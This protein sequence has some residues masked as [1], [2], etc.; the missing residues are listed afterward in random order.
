MSTV[1]RQDAPSLVI[2]G[3]LGSGLAGWE[4]SYGVRHM[5]ALPDSA[6][7]S[8]AVYAPRYAA[9]LPPKGWIKQTLARTDL[10][11]YPSQRPVNHVKAKPVGYATLRLFASSSTRLDGAPLRDLREAFE[12]IDAEGVLDAP[13]GGQITVQ[14]LHRNY[15]SGP[16]RVG[17]TLADGSLEISPIER[18]L[19]RL[20]QHTDF[21]GATYSYDARTEF[22]PSAVAT[23]TILGRRA[24]FAF[25]RAADT[26]LLA[27]TPTRTVS[28]YPLVALTGGAA[29]KTSLRVAST[30]GFSSGARLRIYD[31]AENTQWADFTIHTVVNATDVF[32]IEPIPPDFASATGAPVV[33]LV[34]DPLALDPLLNGFQPG[35]VMVFSD[36]QFAVGEVQAARVSVDRVE[37]DLR[38]ITLAPFLPATNAEV[39]AVTATAVGPLGAAGFVNGQQPAWVSVLPVDD[40]SAMV[41]EIGALPATGWR[42]RLFNVVDGNARV[43][44]LHSIDTTSNTLRF[45]GVGDYIPAG[46]SSSPYPAGST[47]TLLTGPADQIAVASLDEWFLTPTTQLNLTRELPVFLYDFTLA[48]SWRSASGVFDGYP[49]L[50]LVGRNGRELTRLPLRTLDNGALYEDVSLSES[51]TAGSVFRRRIWRGMLESR[52][53]LPGMLELTLRAGMVGADVGDVTVL[54]GDYSR[55]HD[56]S[57]FDDASV[58]AAADRRSA[59]DRLYAAPDVGGLPRGTVIMYAGGAVCPSGWKRVDAGPNATT[60]GF[61]LLPYPDS[62]QYDAAR[63][64]TVLT[65][66]DR[67]FDLL[68]AEGR[69]IPIAGAEEVRALSLPDG[70]SF[71][72]PG[73]GDIY[74]TVVVGPVQQRPQPGM[75]LRVRATS[76]LDPYVR[77][78]DY[79]T[80]VRHASAVRTEVAGAV[81]FATAP[82]SGIS[83]PYFMWSG[84]FMTGESNYPPVGPPSTVSGLPATVTF[85]P[86]SYSGISYNAPFFNYNGAGG[87]TFYAKGYLLAGYGSF[88]GEQRAMFSGLAHGAPTMTLNNVSLPNLT[89]GKAIYVRWRRLV[90]S[91]TSGVTNTNATVDKSHHGFVA[92][93]VAYTP[94]ATANGV[95][96]L[97]VKRYDGNSIVTDYGT[98]IGGIAAVTDAIV[99]HDTVII[100]RT[101][102]D[103]AGQT[104]SIWSARR[105]SATTSLAVCGDVS[106]DLA[107]YNG[108]GVLLEPA[109][110]IRY[111][112]PGAY[113]PGSMAH[114]H[115][116]TRGDAPFNENIAPHVNQHSS[117]SAT[118]FSHVARKHGHGPLG[119]ASHT[120]P[121]FFSVLLCEKL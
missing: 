23:V 27:E 70:P 8:G 30:Y 111:A 88:I 94:P 92:E 89:V 108:T 24:A 113:D 17:R 84:A 40:V 19:P 39:D 18:D 47:A 96:T 117:V 12:F 76:Y 78:F 1:R 59:V 116:V 14:D 74:E 101:P 64:R 43:Y 26:S 93:V 11:R 22:N 83:Y 29:F 15:M 82:Y 80:T 121:P 37:V 87:S 48:L 71:G 46:A 115:A 85:Q 35:D 114:A 36:P 54:R 31:G 118:P 102:V 32:L 109:G 107:A 68:D 61:E 65:W 79:S 86:E 51:T 33:L 106:A 7:T 95:G 9:S 104:G 45:G 13:L 120:M 81:P 5:E 52:R 60:D 112:E 44:T 28:I 98:P 77:R 4:T 105:F 34:Y 99:F 90:G 75:A 67:S 62:V 63:D 100:T 50:R 110:Y 73:Y 58:A 41:A 55:R 97:V 56:Y 38:P 3:L 53:P 20:A 49:E 10:F 69:T 119:R 57:D 2:N 42:V 91:V 25:N 66:Q 72:A 16:Y 103:A 6:A 21:L